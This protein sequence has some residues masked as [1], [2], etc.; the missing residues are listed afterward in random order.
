MEQPEDNR[1]YSAFISHD[2]QDAGVAQKVCAELERSG[3]R[4]WA[5]PRDVRPGQEYAEEI[6][7]GIEL[8]KCLVLILSKRANSSNFVRAEVERADSKGKPIFPFRVED[9][10]PSRSLELFISTKHWIDAWQ[11]SLAQHTDRLAKEIA[12]DPSVNLD[13]APAL[14]RRVRFHRYLR[15]AG[16]GLGAAAI[17]GLVAYLMQPPPLEIHAEHPATAFFMGGLV[18][19]GKPIQVS[20]MLTD[21]WG[22]DGEPYGALDKVSAFQAYEISPDGAPKLILDADPK[23]FADQYRATRSYG[24]TIDGVPNRLSLASFTRFPRPASGKPFCRLSVSACQTAPPQAF[25][26]ARLPRRKRYQSITARTA[27]TSSLLR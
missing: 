27:R 9:V 14:R 12:L 22:N 24:F 21:G 5:A 17:A 1:G 18:C 11:G 3:F 15:L 19:P 2:S 7:R 23:Q 8:S 26:R 25:P 13:I 20:Y 10:L 16:L 4:C 6:V